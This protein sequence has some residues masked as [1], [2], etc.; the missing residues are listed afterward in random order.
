M[1]S[2]FVTEIYKSVQG[3]SSFAGLPCSFIRLSGCPLRCRWCDTSYSFKEGNAL[4]I[5][6][7]LK[8]IKE[9]QVPLVEI[10][11]GEPLAQ[12]NCS[13]LIDE[14]L[15]NNYQVLLETGG[16]LPIQSLPPKTHIIMDLKCPGSGMADKNLFENISFIKPTDEIKFV[17]ASKS[18]FLW[19]KEIIA[20]YNLTEKA[21]L[22]FSP[23]W[24]LVKPQDL[25]EWLLE[26]S[27]PARL[28]LQQ[29]KYI[30]SPRKKGV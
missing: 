20:K 4:L 3:E 27:L 23:A 30:W 5:G 18:D 13:Q 21:Q 1:T 17:V 22:L 7:I 11:G 9:L 12:E 24:G 6:E 15:A 14:L 2:L 8:K 25:V 16:S 28:N 19:S 10:T 29:H 26:S